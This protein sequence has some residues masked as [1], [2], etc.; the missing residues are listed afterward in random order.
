M[1][2][3]FENDPWSIDRC[4][5]VPPFGSVDRGCDPGVSKTELLSDH[6]CPVPG[7]WE[8]R[9][10]TGEIDEIAAGSFKGREPPEIR[11][12]GFVVRSLEAALWAFD[13]SRS[14]EEGCLMAVHLGDDA[15]FGTPRS[16]NGPGTV[17]WLLATGILGWGPAGA[18]SFATFQID[19]ERLRG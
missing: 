10:L 8:R 1:R 3:K 15:E 11:G 7:Y 14:F 19:D 12:T 16:S 17:Q 18:F 2:R 6:Y 4:R 13:R 9:P 5:C